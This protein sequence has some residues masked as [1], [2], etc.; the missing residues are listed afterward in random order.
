MEGIKAVP[1]NAQA[2]AK[3]KAEELVATFK[4]IPDVIAAAA[5]VGNVVEWGVIKPELSCCT[6]FRCSYPMIDP[7]CDAWPQSASMV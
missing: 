2:T 7:L 1:R 6:S 5:K 4:N 3:R